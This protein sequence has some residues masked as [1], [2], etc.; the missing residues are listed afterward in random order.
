MSTLKSGC[1]S[2]TLPFP[3]LLDFKLFYWRFY[4][5]RQPPLYF[6]RTKSGYQ[7]KKTESWWIKRSLYDYVF[8]LYIFSYRLRH[9]LSPT[10][11]VSNWVS[12]RQMVREV[13][14]SSI[15]PNKDLSKGVLRGL[16]ASCDTYL[17]CMTILFVPGI[18]WRLDFE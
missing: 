18:E 10:Y 12:Y 1:F 8:K 6:R 7:T 15:V 13:R 2:T 11:R 14:G 17:T 16:D 3:T 4:I 5:R 9:Q